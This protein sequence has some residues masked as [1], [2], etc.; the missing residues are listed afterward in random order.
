M[1][2]IYEAVIQ[3]FLSEDVMTAGSVGELG[4]DASE[5]FVKPKKKKKKKKKKILESVQPS[6]FAAQFDVDKLK[7]VFKKPVYSF[8]DT[9]YAMQFFQDSVSF[10]GKLFFVGDD[11]FAIRFNK[12]RGND[13]E[14]IDS[15]SIWAN[16]QMELKSHDL[17]MPSRPDGELNVKGIDL[18]K[19]IDI[20]SQIFNNVSVDKVNLK[21]FSVEND[22]INKND[23]FL[24]MIGNKKE[25]SYDDML[26][27]VR[28]NDL[29]VT[30]S[31]STKLDLKVVLPIKISPEEIVVPYQTEYKRF[32]EGE[33]LV[34]NGKILINSINMQS[35]LSNKIHLTEILEFFNNLH[36]QSLI[37]NL[38]V[39]AVIF[40]AKV[41]ESKHKNWLKLVTPKLS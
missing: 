23:E 14:M 38:S 3:K 10:V 4:Q 2:K 9:R 19:C 13:S 39:P 16:W 40:S 28:E 8:G 24:E 18:E 35:M 41:I 12:K 6:T 27:I 26:D 20:A 25:I 34:D 5:L 1:T 21:S 32:H 15:I 30:H 31:E 36:E 7:K 17:M 33:K 29:T 11:G 37:D 22:G